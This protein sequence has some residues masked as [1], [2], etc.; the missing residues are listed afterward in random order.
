MTTETMQELSQKLRMPAVTL[1]DMRAEAPAFEVVSYADASRRACVALRA[2]GGALLVV[3]GN[4]YDL[5]TQDWIESRLREP[6]G[7]RV[8]ERHDVAAYLSQQE[9][10]LRALDGISRDAGGDAKADGAQ[11]ISLESAADGDGTVVR[12]VTSTLYDALKTGASDVHL[13]SSATGLTIKY[14]IDGVLTPGESIPG[15]ELAEQVISR[16]KVMSELDIAER[17]VPQDGRFRAH[18]RNG[19]Q[20]GRDIDVRVSVMPSVVINS[21][22]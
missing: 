8:A 18:H 11:D 20:A 4:P 7:Y 21:R 6:F 16:V 22:V 10:E 15:T 2:S 1:D 13:E 9:R 3:L 17:R 19:I 5:D 12:L 14:R